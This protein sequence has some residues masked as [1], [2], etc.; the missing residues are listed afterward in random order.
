LCPDPLAERQAFDSRADLDDR[1]DDLVAGNDGE[2]RW[3]A[4]AF[5]LALDHVELRAAD[6]A[7]MDPDHDLTEARRR[8]GAL[9]QLD[10]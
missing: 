2:H 1:A 5:P 9:T 4:T 7:G 10:R 3:H 6:T 8:L